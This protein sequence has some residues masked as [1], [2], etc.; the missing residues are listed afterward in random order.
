MPCAVRETKGPST[1]VLN[2]TGE[3]ASHDETGTHEESEPEQEVYINHPHPNAPRLVYTNMSMS[4][5]K[6][7]EMDWTVSDA[8]Y[9]S[10]SGNSNMRIF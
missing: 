10:S 5:I 7:L 9:H 6:G 1:S 4:Y 2:E 3:E 8:L